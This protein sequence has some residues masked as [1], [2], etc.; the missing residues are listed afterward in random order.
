MKTRF[1]IAD[2]I[3]L[4]ASALSLVLLSSCA[5]PTGAVKRVDRLDASE[6]RD[7]SGDWNDAD[8]QLTSREMIAD[9]LSRAWLSN[10]NATRPGR[11]PVVVVGDIKNRTSEHI[12]PDT[13]VKDLERELINSGRVGFVADPAQRQ[14]I[15]DEIRYQQMHASSSTAKDVGRHVGADF[16]ILGSINSILDRDGN[17]QIKY[18][19][20]DLEMIEIESNM[21]VWIGNKKIKKY[22]QTRKYRG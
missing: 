8:S 6:I 18:Y 19:Q 22:V 1:P 3:L 2:R 16:I 7:L 14:A 9:C 17:E 13:F 12:N 20:V 5:A 11:L 10:W 15:I 21:K 4:I